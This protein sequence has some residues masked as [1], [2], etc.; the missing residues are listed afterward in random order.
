MQ[1]IKRI[2]LGLGASLSLVLSAYCLQAAVFL[3]WW[4][5]TPSFPKERLEEVRLKT[6][7]SLLAVAVFFIVAMVCLFFLWRLF[8][9]KAKVSG[10]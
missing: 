6:D 3:A 9:K 2:L 4:E 7:L 8:R 1:D 5:V 10:S